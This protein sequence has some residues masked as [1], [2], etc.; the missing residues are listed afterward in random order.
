MSNATTF[1]GLDVHARSVKA[2]AFI[3]ET[4]ETIRKSFGYEPGEIAS[5]ASS[6]PQPAKCVYESGVT[7]FHLCRELGSMGVDCVIGAVSKM[8]KPAADRGRK[9]D[10]RD[11]RFLAV[12]LALGVVPRCTCPIPSARA[13]GI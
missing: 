3:P 10:R 1:V 2:C 6:L 4:G 9:T 5:W 7:G 11:A 13:R 12:Q 8:H